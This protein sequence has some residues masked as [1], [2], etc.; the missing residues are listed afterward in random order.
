[1]VKNL[2]WGTTT[3]KFGVSVLF[4]NQS[5]MPKEPTITTVVDLK[6]NLENI[7]DELEDLKR[8]SIEDSIKQ[9][10]IEANL[11]KELEEKERN[12]RIIAEQDSLLAIQRNIEIEKQAKL[13]LEKEEFNKMIEAENKRS[14]KICKCFVI[15]FISTQDK[16]EAETTLSKLNEIGISNISIKIF[17]EPY[18]KTK[19]YR[20]QSKCYNNHLSAFDDRNKSYYLLSDIGLNPQILCNR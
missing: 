19:Y 14:G 17:N 9:F 10:Q 5:Y 8:K 7:K 11:R 20:V 6:T 12:R 3:I 1:M 2:E 16:T 18:L 4:S 13:E 15:M